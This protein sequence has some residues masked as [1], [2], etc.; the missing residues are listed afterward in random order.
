MAY[1]YLDN[2]NWV[3]ASY[4]WRAVLITCHVINVNAIA[5][6]LFENSTVRVLKYS[7][8]AH[9]WCLWVGL[10]PAGSKCYASALWALGCK[11]SPFSCRAFCQWQA[12]SPP[13]LLFCHA[14]EM[15]LMY[16]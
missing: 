9:P 13:E 12:F 7:L 15:D 14:G 10:G 2:F 3:E 4:T 1:F 11:R 16:K 5:E 8:L 6:E